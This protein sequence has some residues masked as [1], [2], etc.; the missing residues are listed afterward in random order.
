[1]RI[2]H[3]VVENECA[4]AYARHHLMLFGEW[5]VFIGRDNEQF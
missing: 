3:V 2:E 4:G 5:K 1:M